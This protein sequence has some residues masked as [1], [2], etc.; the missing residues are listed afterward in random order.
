MRHRSGAVNDV[1]DK[2]VPKW[3]HDPA[4]PT[5][6]SVA[7]S[8]CPDQWC[9]FCTPSLTILPHIVINST[10]FKS[11]K[12]GGHSWVGIN[13]GVSSCNNPMV[14]YVR[15]AFQVSQG[16]VETLFKLRWKTFISLCSKFIQETLDQILL[17]SPKFYRRY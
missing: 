12:F 17:E 11:G 15:W 3:R 9:I 5:P 4:W 10:G 2:W 13:S 8:V 1:T 6:F 14:T 7:V 16:S